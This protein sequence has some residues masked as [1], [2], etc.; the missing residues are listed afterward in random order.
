MSNQ[1]DKRVLVRRGARQLTDEEA[2]SVNGG[3]LHTLTVCTFF[4]IGHLDGDV[5][6]C[7]V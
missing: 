2:V 6:E 3:A 4:G 5:N 7:N 1:D